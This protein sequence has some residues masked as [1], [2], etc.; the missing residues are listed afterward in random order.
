[1]NYIEVEIS[2][3]KETEQ[4]RE[5]TI[6]ELANAGYDSFIETESGLKAY[7]IEPDYDSSVLNTLSIF[8]SDAFKGSVFSDTIIPET[9]WNKEWE[10]S[11]EAVEVED[12]CYIRT[13]FH[14]SSAKHRIEVLIEPKMSFGTGHHSTTWLMISMMKEVDFKG[15][16]VL[17]MGCGTGVLG[18]AASLLG[19]SKVDAV[20]IDEWAYK[21]AIENIHLN[22]I[23]NCR[24]I[25]GDVNS[26]PESDYNML[27]A[28]ITRNILLEDLPAYSDIIMPGGILILSGFYSED[29]DI[30][31][32]KATKMGFIYNKT[33][34]RNNW[35]SLFFNYKA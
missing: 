15:I 11:F 26:A 23:S 4:G 16:K 20:D 22:K 13:S 29:I 30:I 34:L 19:A 35:A 5:I 17:D 25:H 8:L 2:I 6:A 1:M 32:E 18:I 31:R 33:M 7:I 21:N 27:M 9:N 24:I 10:S 14:N 28:N 3:P 12:F